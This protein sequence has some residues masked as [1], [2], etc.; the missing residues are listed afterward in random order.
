MDHS[1][2][3]ALMVEVGNLF[4]QDE[5]FEQRRATLAGFQRVL[6]IVDAHALIGW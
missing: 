6:I 2:G 1:F 3:N 5:I 4:A